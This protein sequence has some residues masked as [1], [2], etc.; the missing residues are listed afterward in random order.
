M[1]IFPLITVKKS[2]EIQPVQ[3]KQANPRRSA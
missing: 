2:Y 3:V 1:R